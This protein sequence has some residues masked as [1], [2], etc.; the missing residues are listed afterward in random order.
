MGVTFSTDTEDLKDPRP[1]LRLS[2]RDVAAVVEAYTSHFPSPLLDLQSTRLLVGSFGLDG[3]VDTT[4]LT[5]AIWDVFKEGPGPDQYILPTR[6]ALTCLVLLSEE[7]WDIRVRHLF[8]L[9]RNLGVEQIFFDDLLLMARTA[10]R[11][12]SKLWRTPAFLDEEAS[13]L[14]DG[15]GNDALV[16]MSLSPELPIPRDRFVKWVLRRFRDSKTIASAAALRRIYE[17]AFDSMN[18][19]AAPA[20][21][22]T[23]TLRGAR[24]GES[25]IEA[26]TETETESALEAGSEDP[27]SAPTE[28]KAHGTRGPEAWGPSSELGNDGLAVE[29]K[30]LEN[31]ENSLAAMSVPG[32][33]P[34]ASSG[35]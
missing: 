30:E 15:L 27:P 28:E 22:P 8:E 23:A 3:E 5:L 13:T 2:G 9:F 7:S 29:G 31:E 25:E 12:L 33:G 18:T 24:G 16:E 1:T 26:E 17:T 32:P 34:E 35:I 19:T 21:E 11:A 6:E 10:E 20:P 4:A 14:A